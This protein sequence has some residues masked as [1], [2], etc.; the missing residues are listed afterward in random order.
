[1]GLRESRQRT[2]V[3]VVN[4]LAGS[5]C[6]SG[7]AVAQACERTVF[8]LFLSRIVCDHMLLLEWYEVM[9][10]ADVPMLVVFR[11]DMNIAYVLSLWSAVVCRFQVDPRK[12]VEFVDLCIHI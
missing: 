11:Y 10:T 2:C 12:S 5:K 9:N 4:L 6:A 7:R 1:M 8:S 3:R